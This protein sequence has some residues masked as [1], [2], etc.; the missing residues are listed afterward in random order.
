LKRIVPAG[1]VIVDASGNSQTKIAFIEDF[2]THLPKTLW[3]IGTKN[4]ALTEFILT[5]LLRAV[6]R[7]TL[8]VNSSIISQI[9]Q[10]LIPFF[11]V[12]H[13]TRGAI[14]GPYRQ[15]QDVDGG[16]TV[17]RLALDLVFSLHHFRS[18]ERPGRRSAPNMTPS[19]S[20]STEL[21][22]AVSSATLGTTQEMHWS[23]LLSL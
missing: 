1:A 2:L 17:Q 21:I 13:P 11:L 23:R 16:L 20:S 5:Y 10:R 4:I 3:E 8:E 15:F 14:F 19:D 12:Q 7:R 18:S 6:Q 22:R 9:L